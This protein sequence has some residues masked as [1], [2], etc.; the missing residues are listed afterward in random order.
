M[1]VIPS[2]MSCSAE[3]RK[4]FRL[5]QHDSLSTFAR[6]LLL[7]SRFL[8][9]ELGNEVNPGFRMRETIYT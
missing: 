3:S 8:S 4:M 6:S 9:L 2:G 1:N 7:S 5:A